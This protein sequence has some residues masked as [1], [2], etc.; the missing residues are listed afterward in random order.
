MMKKLKKF[1]TERYN[2]YNKTLYLVDARY[3]L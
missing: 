2:A 1:I 3:G